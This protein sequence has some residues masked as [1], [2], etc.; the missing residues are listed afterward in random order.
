MTSKPPRRGPETTNFSDS[1]DKVDPLGPPA[2]Q[3][4]LLP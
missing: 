3:T 1:S 2:A 4:L